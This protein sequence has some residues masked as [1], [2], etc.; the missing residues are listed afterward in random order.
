MTS[1]TGN[2][3]PTEIEELLASEHTGHLGCSA[4]GEVY[5]VPITFVYSDDQ[6]YGYTH[7][8]KKIDMMRHNPQVCVQVERVAMGN[9][10]KSVIVWGEYHEIT[11]PAKQQEVRLHIAEHFAK[12]SERGEKVVTPLIADVGDRRSA[13]DLAPIVYRIKIDRKTGRFERHR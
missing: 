9:E 6:M 13:T 12:G 2:L 8:G 1:H 10:W 4:N 7:E 11:D 3:S 5:V